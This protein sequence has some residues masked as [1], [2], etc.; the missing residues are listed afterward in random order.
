MGGGGGPRTLRGG[1]GLRSGFQGL[2][3][4]HAEFIG[5]KFGM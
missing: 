4:I 1:L 2:G 5:L 3:L